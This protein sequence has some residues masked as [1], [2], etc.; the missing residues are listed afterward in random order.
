MELAAEEPER[1]LNDLNTSIDSFLC[2]ALRG[3]PSSWSALSA[4]TSPEEFLLRCQH[5]GIASLLYHTMQQQEEWLSW[6]P[7]LRNALEETSKGDIAQEMLRAHYLK[8]LLK[9]F[10]DLGVPCLLTKGEALANTL[11]PTPGTRTRCDSDLFIPIDG[12]GKATQAVADAGFAIV[13]PVYKSHQFTVRREGEGPDV[14]EFDVHWRILNAPR[15]ART[16]SFDETYGHSIEVPG[17]ESVRTLDVVDTLLLACMHR[18]GSDGHD[19]DRLIWIYDIHLLVAAMAPEQWLAFADKA[20]RLN[21]QTPCLDG[22]NKS[23]ECLGTD[24]PTGAMKQLSSP[25][26]PRTLSRRYAQS[27]LGLLIDD[28]KR[29]PD[30]QA[31]REL[32]HELFLP[33]GESLLRKYHKEERWWLPLLY[34]RHI[35]S[36]LSQRLTLR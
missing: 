35:F 33:N 21:V 31:R 22:L 13:S 1:L 32:L 18:A 2:R 26:T 23:R 11:Y 16:L 15:Y 36:G 25:E 14:F 9:G 27:N 29:L 12:I 8:K 3:E 28:W 17:M 34:L 7:D 24:L 20:V 6:P 5:H 19:P 4:G 30:S 10:S